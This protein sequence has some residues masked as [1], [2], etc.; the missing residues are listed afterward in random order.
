[1]ESDNVDNMPL[2]S[3][4]Q[5]NR[6]VGVFIRRYRVA[7]NLTGAELGEMV[8]LSQQQISRYERGVTSMT[9][10]Q[11]N[12]FMQVLGFSWHDFFKE[13]IALKSRPKQEARPMNTQPVPLPLLGVNK[14]KPD[15]RSVPQT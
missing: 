3:S 6:A 5:F 1:M 15:G 4:P 9:L 14:I 8:H 12:L 10:Y 13:V 11:L 2:I 7:L